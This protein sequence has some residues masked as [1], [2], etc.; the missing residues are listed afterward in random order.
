MRQDGTLELFD[1]ILLP[2]Y[3][4]Q[5]SQMDPRTGQPYRQRRGRGAT[6][7][8]LASMI[9]EAL[10]AYQGYWVKNPLMEF[11]GWL[12]FARELN[13]GDQVYNKTTGDVYTIKDLLYEPDGSFLGEVL[14][15]GGSDPRE[16]DRLELDKRSSIVFGHADPRSE[17]P[18]ARFTESGVKV[19]KP[20]P[21]PEVIE[22]SVQRMEPG[23]VGKRPFDRERQAVPMLRESNLDDLVDPGIGVDVKGQ[24]FDNIVQFDLFARTNE[25]LYGSKKVNGTG[26]VGLIKWF[27]DFMLRYNWVFQWNGITRILDWQSTRDQAVSQYRND[28]VHRPLLYYVRTEDVSMARFRRIA[29]IDV[30]VNIGT[31]MEL[32]GSGA[33]PI[34]TGQIGTVVNDMGLY[35]SLGGP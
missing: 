7:M 6:I 27:K 4:E 15:S 18:S 11:R 24:W 26:T 14:L 33:V 23:T 25:V 3:M 28:M 35:Q 8:D 20:A 32:E 2:N 31:P 29:R 13:V 21:F 12:Q 19:D 16:T 22:W 1:E 10:T 30:L 5:A 34:P 17:V 9:E